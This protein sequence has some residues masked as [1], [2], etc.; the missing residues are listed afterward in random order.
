MTEAPIARTLPLVTAQVK[1]SGGR[2]RK[3]DFVPSLRGRRGAA[4][5]GGAADGAVLMIQLAAI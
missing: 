2:R 1:I 4:S 5:P 3:T